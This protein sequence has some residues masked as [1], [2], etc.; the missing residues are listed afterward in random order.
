MDKVR[1][2]SRY[3]YELYVKT[4]VSK[5]LIK[6][7]S[8]PDIVKKAFIDAVMK[9]FDDGI[10]LGLGSLYIVPLKRL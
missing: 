6:N 2:T 1:I 4:S 10:K 7:T 5:I 3:E 9:A 8:K